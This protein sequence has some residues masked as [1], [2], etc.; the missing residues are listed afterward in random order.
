MQL[1]PAH[2]AHEGPAA[3]GKYFEPRVTHEAGGALGGALRGRRLAGRDADLPQGALRA[4][5]RERA[6]AWHA[7]ARSRHAVRCLKRRW[8]DVSGDWQTRPLHAD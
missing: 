3:V 4:A 6:V 1:V 5:A 7:S 2:V 8:Q